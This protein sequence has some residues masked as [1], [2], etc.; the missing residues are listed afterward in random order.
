MRA[1]QNFVATLKG[2]STAVGAVGAAA[3]LVAAVLV[4]QSSSRS[5]LDVQLSDGGVWLASTA[6]GGVSLLDGGS[7]TIAA[8][9]GVA[10]P[11]DEFSVEQFGSDAVIVNQ[12][13]GTVARLDGSSWEIPTGRVQFGVPGQPISVVTSK[14]G[15][16]LMT[17]G[18]ATTLELEELALRTPVPVAAPFADGIITDDGA[19]LYA[20]TDPDLPVQRFEALGGASSNVA[21]LDGPTALIDLGGSVAAVDLDDRT[22][23]LDG[24]GI[25]CEQ[26]EFPEGATLSAGGGDGLLI[27][28]SDQG[29][30]FVWSP[31]ESGCPDANDF[32]NLGPGDYGKPALTDGWAVIPERA[33]SS[34]LVIDLEDLSVTNRQELEGVEA[35]TDVSLIAEDGAIWYNDP[36]SAHAGLVR[37]DGTVVPIAKYEEGTTGF[38]SAPVE[39]AP[40]GADD[41]SLAGAQQEQEEPEE[42]APEAEQVAAP[43]LTTTTVAGAGEEPAAATTTTEPG[44]SETTDPT[45]TTDPDTSETTDTTDPET[46]DPQTTDTIDPTGP[47][48]TVDPNA[49]T[50]TTSTT[51]EPAAQGLEVSIG[52]SARSVIAGESINFTVLVQHGSISDFGLPQISPSG[53]T[54]LPAETIG[55]FRVLFPDV[56]TYSL[57]W[58]LCDTNDATD[59]TTAITQVTIVEDPDAIPLIAA[60]DGPTTVLV[61]ETVTFSDISQGDPDS[62][63]WGANTGASNTSGSNSTFDT[64]W[65][66][67]GEKQV[68]L[69]VGRS[70]VTRSA[71]FT[72]NVVAAPEPAPFG[73]LCSP[74]SVDVGN[75]SNCQLDGDVADF[76]DIT[77]STSADGAAGFTS[78]TPSAGRLTL[79]SSQE[80]TVTV[81]LSVT[82]DATGTTLTDTAAITFNAPTC[83]AV[84]PTVTVSGATTLEVGTAGNFTGTPE[85]GCGNA[86]RLWTATGGGSITNSTAASTNISWATAG[87]YTVTYSFS[88]G[89]GSSSRNM[90]V[91]VEEPVAGPTAPSVSISGSTTLE[92]NETGTYSINNSGGPIDSYS[93]ST[94]GGGG[95]GSGQ[96]F[97]ADWSAA[98]TYTV[99]LSVSGPGGDDT[100]TRSVTVEAPAPTASPFGMTCDRVSATTEQMVNCDLTTG[101][102]ANF[103][104]PQWSSTGGNSWLMNPWSYDAQGFTA[105]TTMTVT[106]TAV[107][108]ATGL[109]VSNTASISITAPVVQPATMTVGCDQGTATTDDIVS[110]DLTS[111]NAGSFS[112]P[113]WSVSCGCDTGQWNM[114]PFS[115]D[116]QGFTAGT[117]TVTLT[118]TD[119]ATG[120]VV[121]A[122]ASISVSAPAPTTTAPPAP[123]PLTISCSVGSA[124]VGQR[125]NC[126]LSSGNAGSFSGLTWTISP[127]GNRT[128]W[129]G[130]GSIDMQGDVAGTLSI[131]L[132]GTDIATGQVVS[133]S[134]SVVIS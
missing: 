106:L 62:H 73:L 115:Y 117:M 68:T 126:S 59:C 103:S 46:T 99:T 21:D 74:T 133:A 111:G 130:G 124:A 129:G 29:G 107:D 79:S 30:A 25:V 125:F 10:D 41:M 1:F 55:Q 48:V 39:D 93:W 14:G 101:N 102:S 100:A 52:A 105:G 88:D 19:L 134:T 2:R 26:L 6:V 84:L 8:S 90:T 91:T 70:G 17:P 18:Q 65:T 4:V 20:S 72:V 132:A 51:E 50:S 71:T 98:G 5:E 82:D 80:R 56:G 66:F 7:G 127:V 43:E 96:T 31:E 27:V 44:T 3:M 63:T 114:A 121:S 49:S 60:I 120:Q 109:T 64:S 34:V 119:V 108:N 85:T 61:D 53:P 35:G 104:N 12:T 16:W 40:D 54:L 15:G 116:V 22:V 81:T 83:P 87:T 9:L 33:T 110:C 94:N 75:S 131:S 89:G 24:V 77:Y 36:A 45:D 57:S 95:S 42:I 118:A 78:S 122:S 128:T 38:T 97:S 112:G 113:S 23:W 11:G 86:T 58:T 67:P 47:T 32:I 28:I 69:T 76:S 13:D 37:R 123:Q 92:T